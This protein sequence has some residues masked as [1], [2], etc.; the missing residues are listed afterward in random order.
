MKQK[1]RKAENRM[2]YVAEYLKWR[3]DLSFSQAP[4]CEADSLILTMLSYLSPEDVLPF[5][6]SLREISLRDLARIYGRYYRPP[7]QVGKL[8]MTARAP[9]LL[10]LLS[11]S[12]RF[13]GVRLT[14]YDVFLDEEEQFAAMTFASGERSVYV[15]FRGTDENLS[16]WREDFNLACRGSGPAQE[17]AVRYLNRRIGGKT[18]AVILGG[19]SKGGNLAIYAAAR[20]DRAVR[21]RICEIHSFD[22]PGFSHEFLN[23]ADYRRIEGRVIHFMPQGSLVGRLFEHR[24]EVRIVESE[25][26]GILQH[27][28]FN[29]KILGENFVPAESFDTGSELFSDIMKNWIGGLEDGEKRLFIDALFDLLEDTGIERTEELR[30]ELPKVK[31]LLRSIGAMPRESRENLLKLLGMLLKETGSAVQKNVLSFWE[32]DTQH[33]GE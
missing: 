31:R 12:L 32:D 16:G 24:A 4:F 9:E 21:S 30:V 28:P 25:S 22:G 11:V 7:E 19:H 20:A 17:S 13:S 8:S 6:G 2:G 10:A 3:G 23:G 18:E 27:V 15:A 26:R 5:P 1:S 29:W 14:G 33:F